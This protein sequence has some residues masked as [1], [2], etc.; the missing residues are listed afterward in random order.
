M[1]S[2]AE[3]TMLAARKVVNCR[4]CSASA[5]QVLDS[6]SPFYLMWTCRSCCIYFAATTSCRRCFLKIRGREE[7]E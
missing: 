7:A 5:R 6:K 2:N 4:W 1:M 3:I